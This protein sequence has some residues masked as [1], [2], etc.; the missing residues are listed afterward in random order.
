MKKKNGF[1]L[2]EI[3]VTIAIMLAIVGIAVPSAMGLSSK[4]KK[5]SYDLQ[6][7]EFESAAK[8]YALDNKNKWNVTSISSS[9]KNY[10]FTLGDLEDSEYIEEIPKNPITNKTFTGSV[11]ITI[12]TSSSGKQKLKYTYSD[13]NCEESNRIVMDTNLKALD[14][15]DSYLN[16]INNNNG[17]GNP[18]K[19]TAIETLVSFGESSNFISK[20]IFFDTYDSLGYVPGIHCEKIFGNDNR[21]CSFVGAVDN[22]YIKIPGVKYTDDIEYAGQKNTDMLW[23]IVSF[24]EKNNSIKLI[25][26]LSV[27]MSEYSRDHKNEN[28]AIWTDGLPYMFGKSYSYKTQEDS[29][30][31]INQNPFTRG[32]LCQELTSK[33]GGDVKEYKCLPQGCT[34][35]DSIHG[36][37]SGVKLDSID[38]KYI[39]SKDGDWGWDY[40][41]KKDN[42]LNLFYKIDI[43]ASNKYSI[44]QININ[45]TNVAHPKIYNEIYSTWGNK[46]FGD[47]FYKKKGISMSEKDINLSQT[48]DGKKI[49]VFKKTKMCIPTEPTASKVTSYYNAYLGSGNTHYNEI[50][51]PKFNNITTENIYNCSYMDNASIEYYQIGLL[52]VAEYIYSGASITQSEVSGNGEVYRIIFDNK[53]IS[54]TMFNQNKVEFWTSDL[55]SSSND[56]RKINEETSMFT[57]PLNDGSNSTGSIGKD[58]Y[59]SAGVRP[60]ITIDGSVKFK[61]GSGT[62]S[63]PYIVCLDGV[64]SDDCK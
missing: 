29:K 11:Q 4:S 50:S 15:Y 58:A 59:G 16:L 46:N 23:R 49:N 2:V 7:K 45:T 54:N 52:S 1:T 5:K 64:N 42:D 62:S 32:E 20:R 48:N 53:N 56:N 14:N 38:C 18:I 63:D 26:D 28:Q 36:G 6:I 9:D 13:K 55:M 34:I 47:D 24:D 27:L 60:V 33:L 22:N 21:Y 61:K 40:I 51:L 30:L 39:N 37:C 8:S 12:D 35:A 17:N 3:V 41:Y 25:S 43:Y 19:D 10:C 44:Y 57:I 31:V